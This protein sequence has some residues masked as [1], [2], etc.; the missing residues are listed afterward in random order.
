MA[1]VT[2][3]LNF[4]SLQF[5]FKLNYHTQ[6]LA[7][8][9]GHHRVGRSTVGKATV[10]LISPTD[11]LRSV[12]QGGADLSQQVPKPFQSPGFLLQATAFL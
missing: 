6:L 5:L 2:E 7:I 3:E 11:L 12:K 10:N 9:T 8:I 1:S 4:N